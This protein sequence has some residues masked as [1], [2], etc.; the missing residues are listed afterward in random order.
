MQFIKWKGLSR[1]SRA[2]LVAVMASLACILCFL[3]FRCIFILFR[4][5]WHQEGD[6]ADEN[7]RLSSM[8]R[9][10]R[11]APS[12]DEEEELLRLVCFFLHEALRS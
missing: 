6:G 9:Y 3:S 7:D 1:R 10:D 8:Q 2:I 4:L 12:D 5:L 11:L